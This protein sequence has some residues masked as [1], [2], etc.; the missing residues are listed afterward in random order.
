MQW[1]YLT[2]CT[3]EVLVDLRIVWIFHLPREKKFKNMNRS[4]VEIYN[5][6]FLQILTTYNFDVDSFGIKNLIWIESGKRKK[7]S[8]LAQNN[9]IM[10]R[11]LNT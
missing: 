7:T 10:H 6:E 1:S 2:T 3:F 8:K 4:V 9:I 11:A 5:W